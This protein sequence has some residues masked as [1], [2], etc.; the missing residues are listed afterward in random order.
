MTQ[1]TVSINGRKYGIECD[2]NDRERVLALA[3]YVDGKIREIRQEGAATSDAHLLVLASL[4]LADTISEQHEALQTRDIQIAE[5]QN[6]NSSMANKISELTAY[7]ENSEKNSGQHLNGDLSNVSDTS[8]N[9]K[10][11][12]EALASLSQRLDNIA[13]RVQK[14]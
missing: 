7:I 4:V 13:D 6:Q 3:G 12:M 2:E 14:V 9:R 1:V 10:I 5:L 11:V 8:E